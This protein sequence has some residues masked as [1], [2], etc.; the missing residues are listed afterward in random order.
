MFPKSTK[1]TVPDKVTYIHL[2]LH[3]CSLLHL[4]SQVKHL[5]DL[6]YIQMPRHLDTATPLVI[7]IHSGVVFQRLALNSLCYFWTA[8]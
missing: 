3:F 6:F 7:P 5:D 2:G 8:R 1:Q 4:F